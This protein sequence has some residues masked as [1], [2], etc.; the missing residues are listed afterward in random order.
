[1]LNCSARIAP[2]FAPALPMIATHSWSGVTITERALC[3]PAVNPGIEIGTRPW[4]EP[5][6]SGPDRCDLPG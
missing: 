1:M 5:M 6:F 3:D 4:G 2:R